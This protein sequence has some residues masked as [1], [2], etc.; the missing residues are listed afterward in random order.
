[1]NP[2][3]RSPAS[4]VLRRAS[5][6]DP[7]SNEI[8]SNEKASHSARLLSCSDH[9]SCGDFRDDVSLEVSEDDHAGHL[10]TD[11][12]SGLLLGAVL[13]QEP[14]VLSESRSVVKLNGL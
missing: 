8:R 5:M 3:Y 11:E 1:M 6:Q 9:G 13:V 4:K 14:H 2:G 10:I 7:E 12:Q